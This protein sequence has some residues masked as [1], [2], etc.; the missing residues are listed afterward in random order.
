MASGR[1]AG[2]GE[3]RRPVVGPGRGARTNGISG[4]MGTIHADAPTGVFSRVVQMVRQATPALPADYALSAICSLDLIVQVRRNRNHER[5]VT[6]I[7]QLQGTIGDNAMPVL[8]TL[9]EARQDGRAVHDMYRYKVK[10]PAESHGKSDDY[11]LITTIP[12]ADAF[13]P[14]DTGGCSLDK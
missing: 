5:F 1:G 13:R 10:A 4:V 9:F 8:E 11:T 6:E 7:A 12:G 14:L 2:G 3:S